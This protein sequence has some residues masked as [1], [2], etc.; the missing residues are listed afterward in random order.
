MHRASSFS[1]STRPLT[2]SPQ[3]TQLA[4]RL[5]S[6][7]GVAAEAEG[8]KVAEVDGAALVPGRDMVHRLGHRCGLE[9]LGWGSGK[10]SLGLGQDL[11]LGDLTMAWRA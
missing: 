2:S 4:S 1:S 11:N 10:Q 3:N 5:P 9:M 8:L 6:L 7:G